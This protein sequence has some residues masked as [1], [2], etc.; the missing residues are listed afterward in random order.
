MA[1]QLTIRNIA[2]KVIKKKVSLQVLMDIAKLTSNFCVKTSKCFFPYRHELGIYWFLT[3]SHLSGR[4]WR[5]SQNLLLKD[6]GKYPGGINEVDCMRTFDCI[7]GWKMITYESK[8]NIF[9]ETSYFLM[10]KF[11][12]YGMLG[13]T[14]LDFIHLQFSVNWL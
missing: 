13:I 5:H 11:G 14:T 10:P 6:N 12:L 2:R 4:K 7:W 3:I 8:I 9:E 1:M